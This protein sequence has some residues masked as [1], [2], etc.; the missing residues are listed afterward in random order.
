MPPD[1]VLSKGAGRDT[2]QRIHSAFAGLH[3]SEALLVATNQHRVEL[4]VAAMG[5]K[6]GE[7]PIHHGVIHDHDLPDVSSLN[8]RWWGVS[9]RSSIVPCLTLPELCISKC[10]EKIALLKVDTEGSECDIIS[11]LSELQESAK[12]RV[13]T[14]EYGGGCKPRSSQMGGWSPEF[15][16]GI[17]QLL[18]TTKKEGYSG[19]IV[20][21]SNRII[22]KLRAGSKAFDAEALFDPDFL[23]GNII[24]VRDLEDVKNFSALI[25]S[26]IHRFIDSGYQVWLKNK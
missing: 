8:P 26:S 12:P 2:H 14:I 15:F 24:I 5:A 9:E 21:E 11:L 3:T 6:S 7:V 23:V 20:L 16:S 1:A 19:T 22:P 10:I 17:C 18:E 4:V 13:I 25:D